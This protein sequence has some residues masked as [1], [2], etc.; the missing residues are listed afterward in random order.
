MSRILKVNR[1]NKKPKVILTTNGFYASSLKAKYIIDC[2]SNG[3]KLI[4]M[5]HGGN[6]NHHKIS[7]TDNFE[8]DVSDKYCTWGW[9]KDYKKKI[10]PLGINKDLSQINKGSNKNTNL[11][12]IVK[13][14]K[15]FSK[16]LDYDNC[17]KLNY[18]YY[19]NFCVD[20]Y[21][22]LKP[23]FQK[24]MIFRLHTKSWDELK[25]FKKKCSGA[26]FSDR[27]KEKFEKVVKKSQLA[28]CSY[29]GTTFLELMASNIPVYFNTSSPIYIYN[30]DTVDLLKILEKYKIFLMIKKWQ[31]LIHL[32]WNEI[33]HWWFNKD[34]QIARK[35]F[36]KKFAFQNENYYNELKA[37]LKAR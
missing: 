6:K 28:I 19:K 14:C 29:L 27:K 9:K 34:L 37:I 22:H 10:V 23:N 13:S 16:Y 8:I 26:D 20:F 21:R 15:R 31:V 2:I 17:P 4:L 24:K 35:L 3:A 30:K 33:E 11:L 32:N 7:F 36:L 12:F 1:I 25:F 18:H 5:Q